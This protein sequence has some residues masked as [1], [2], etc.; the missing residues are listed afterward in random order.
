[1]LSALH[2]GHQ[3]LAAGWAEQPILV[4]RMG[5]LPVWWSPGLDEELVEGVLL[6]G[7]GEWEAVLAQPTASFLSSQASYCQQ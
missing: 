2:A 5:N 1:M 7:V 6:Q 3:L 4:N